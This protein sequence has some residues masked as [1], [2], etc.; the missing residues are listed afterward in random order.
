MSR[1]LIERYNN[2]HL[3]GMEMIKD[4]DV[5]LFIV[6]EKMK[7][8]LV[9]ANLFDVGDER[10]SQMLAQLSEMERP[11]LQLFLA[12][13][14][15]PAHV[16]IQVSAGGMKAQTDLMQNVTRVPFIIFN[17]LVLDPYG[18][19]LLLSEGIPNLIL[20]WREVA[21]RIMKSYSG[22]PKPLPILHSSVARFTEAKSLTEEERKYLVKFIDYWNYDLQKSS[23]GT[24]TKSVFV[25]TVYDLLKSLTKVR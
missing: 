1:F 19:I 15:F 3:A 9:V 20:K 11:G 18:N 16:T 5:P 13:R 4:G 14:D 10:W 22:Q 25:G 12:N 21:S 2:S 23:L 7:E 6:N 17:R 24:H 8:D